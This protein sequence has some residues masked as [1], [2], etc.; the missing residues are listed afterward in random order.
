MAL[1]IDMKK[2]FDFMEWSFI[3]KILESLGFYSKW[4]MWIKEC[5]FTVS[6]SMVINGTPYGFFH[7]SRGLRQVDL[8]SPFLFIIGT[9]VL[10]RLILKEE[11][12][13][14]LK[15]INISRNGPTITHLLFAD[16]LILYGKAFSQNV[17]FFLNYLETYTTRKILNSV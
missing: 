1:K 11:N 9:K 14:N 12:F 7:H 16:D 8:L 3:I 5:I 15:G 4:I 13:D 6:Y 17:Q 10:F 2:T